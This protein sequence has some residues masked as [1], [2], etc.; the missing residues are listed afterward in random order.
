MIWCKCVISKSQSHFR[1]C[2]MK[3]LKPLVLWNYFH[4]F[5]RRIYWSLHLRKRVIT[6]LESNPNLNSKL[7]VKPCI[8]TSGFAQNF[9][10]M[11]T[12]SQPKTWQPMKKALIQSTMKTVALENNISYYAEKRFFLS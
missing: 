11:Q 1:P 2:A 10:S 8:Q 7:P 12:T 4:N 5:Y 6:T 3:K 9:Q